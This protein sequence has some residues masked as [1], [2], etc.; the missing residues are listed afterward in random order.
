MADTLKGK[1]DFEELW[2]KNNYIGVEGT[3]T[4][5]AMG[6]NGAGQGGKSCMPCQSGVFN[7]DCCS[8]LDQGPG[9]WPTR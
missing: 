7:I 8:S 4:E 9:R 5:D 1:L 2:I 3:C 6:G